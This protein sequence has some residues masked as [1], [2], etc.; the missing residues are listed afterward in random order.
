MN[1]EG[2]HLLLVFCALCTQVHNY[3]SLDR[4]GISKAEMVKNGQNHVKAECIVYLSSE[5]CEE[6]GKKDTFRCDMNYK[7]V[8]IPCTGNPWCQVAWRFAKV[9]IL[10]LE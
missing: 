2:T 6:K 10:R 5:V 7:K 1:L 8:Y 3:F 4:C 9:S